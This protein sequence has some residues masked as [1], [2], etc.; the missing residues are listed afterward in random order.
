MFL[1]LPVLQINK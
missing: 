1:A